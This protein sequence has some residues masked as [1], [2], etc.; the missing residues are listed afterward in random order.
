M[1]SMFQPTENAASL[2][3]R[4]VN[5]T[6]IVDS[7]SL[8]N[9]S[10]PFSSGSVT[11]PGTINTSA[12]SSDATGLSSTTSVDG[13]DIVDTVLPSRTNALSRTT[14]LPSSRLSSSPFTQRTSTIN[15]VPLSTQRTST[16]SRTVNDTSQP[17]TS[18]LPRT[19]NESSRLRTVS[20]TSVTR[21]ETFIEETSIPSNRTVTRQGTPVS[22]NRTVTRTVSPSASSASSGPT[23]TRTSLTEDISTNGSTFI[24]EDIDRTVTRTSSPSSSLSTTTFP[25]DV[26]RTSFSQDVT[27]SSRTLAR[28][29]TSSPTTRTSFSESDITSPRT[30]SPRRSTR[31]SFE[32]D[33]VAPTSFNRTVTRTVSP[34]TPSGPTRTTLVEEDISTR[35]SPSPTRRGDTSTR[36]TTR[37]LIEEDVTRSPIRRG[38]TSTRESTFNRTSTSPTRRG[39]TSTREAT[40]VTRTVS[41]TRGA[42]RTL[43]EEDV[44]RTSSSFGPIFPSTRQTLSPSR[45]TQGL[46]SRSTISPVPTIVTLPRTIT[47][48]S[49]QTRTSPRTVLSTAIDPSE[50][51][52]EEDEIS[53]TLQSVRLN[54]FGSRCQVIETHSAVP[55]CISVDIGTTDGDIHISTLDGRHLNYAAKEYSDRVTVTVGDKEYTGSKRVEA[56]WMFDEELILDKDDGG[57][58]KL[59]K[60]DTVESS[61]QGI[62]NMFLVDNNYNGGVRIN[63]TVRHIKWSP[64]NELI[65][66]GNGRMRH[67]I[68][69]RIK[70]KISFNV[71][72]EVYLHPSSD[73]LYDMYR[74]GHGRMK[75]S[76]NEELTSYRLNN[77]QRDVSYQ[78]VH[79]HQADVSYN[80][81]YLIDSNDNRSPCYGYEI[82]F[83]REITNEEFIVYRDG[84]ALSRGYQSTIYNTKTFVEIG[85][86]SSI[87]GEIIEME[88][89]FQSEITNITDNPVTVVIK[90]NTNGER[91]KSIDVP[92]YIIYKGH[93]IIKVDV[94]PHSN[95]SG[96]INVI[97]EQQR[98]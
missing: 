28:T 94:E 89:G 53:E 16:L 75:F 54:I 83:G 58:I 57:W 48:R 95:L 86:A 33:I 45:L 21:Q 6:G 27:S 29:V 73:P 40:V 70:G 39:D 9:G 68:V 51:I 50:D 79:L 93:I 41:P 35:T 64:L 60:V 65:I 80:L 4:T 52:D 97:K 37:T 19:V 63:Y 14:T 67:N 23:R 22:S 56:P 82:D 62:C 10:V 77:I 13:S 84:N 18:T 81:V 72:V 78:T 96:K 74:G 98:Y 44:T 30:L 32:Q 3:R 5:N 15:D 8:T 49:L 25:Q 38:D 91:I 24:E 42:T 31:T 20:P 61:T 88:D 90:I 69:A 47:S 17:R 66:D 85:E 76:T 7:M 12:S 26:T 36:E 87:R 71:P 2:F 11:N 59:K 43:I 46:S 1:T 34:S 55:D 92:K